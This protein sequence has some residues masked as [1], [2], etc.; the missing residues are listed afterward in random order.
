MIRADFHIH[1]NRSDGEHS[2]ARL[3]QFAKRGGLTHVALTDHDTVSGIDAAR[4]A[5]E[6][7]HL[8]FLPGVELSSFDGREVHILGFCRDWT[9]ASL[10]VETNL[11]AEFRARRNKLVFRAL[12]QQ[13]VNVGWEDLRKLYPHA[14]WSRVGRS[15]IAR[16]LVEKK[17]AQN[18][19]DAFSRYIGSTGCAY[20]TADR[21]SVK[22]AIEAVLRN[23]GMPVLAHPKNLNMDPQDFEP[24]L[25]SLISFGLKGIESR[26]FSHTEREAAYYSELAR[27]YSLAETGGS[28]YHG[29]YRN[30]PLG[31]YFTPEE[32]T[33][34]ALKIR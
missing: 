14:S 10:T 8:V 16:L 31:E 22:Q 26:Y 2:P 34:L 18:N 17:Y 6:K 9:S 29:Q 7:Q 32:E 3:M 1:S 13:G 11:A 27:K 20:V 25:Q 23:G 5:A 30:A 21:F 15:H 24:Y 33:M 28:D 19:A 12:Q 4:E